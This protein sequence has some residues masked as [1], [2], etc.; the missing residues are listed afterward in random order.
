MYPTLYHAFLDLFGW[1]WPV[2]K[3]VNSFGFFVAL[4]FVVAAA[5]LRKELDRMQKMGVFKPIAFQMI[6]GKK[7]SPLDIMG[8]G[9]IGFLFGWKFLFLMFNAESLFNGPTSP[10]A[11]LFS[12]SGSL[13]MG[14]LCALIFGGIRWYNGMKNALPTPENRT[15]ELPASEHVGAIVTAAAIGGLSGAKLFHFLEYPDEFIAFVQQP[16]LNAFLGGLTIYGGLIVGG[17][18]VYLVTRMRGL[19]FPH[20]ADATAPG[21]MLAYGIGRIGCQVS[22]DGDWGIPNPNPKPQLLSWLPDWMWSY[23]F[24]NNVNGVYGARSA[25]YTG[26]LIAPEDPW[27]IFD[28]YGTYLDPAVYPTAFYETLMASLIFAGLW[29]LRKRWIQ[30]GKIFAL[31]LMANGLERF[32][33][34]KIRVNVEMDWLGLT[35]TQAEWISM[36]TG[37]SG[38]ALWFYVSHQKIK[39]A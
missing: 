20:I 25:G 21:L 8:Q 13:G 37:L 3:L 4:A 7:A 11:H 39:P 12:G 14:I 31:Y 38:L 6:V 15:V 22:G 17:L 36:A 5:L 35:L 18:S 32:A 1:D 27:P 16:S 2:L 10:Q 19:S 9:L 28:G 29:A 24:P 23:A 34:E 33:I 30:P 26:K